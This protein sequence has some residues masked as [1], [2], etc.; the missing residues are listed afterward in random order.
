[1]YGHL[2]DIQFSLKNYIE[3]RKAWKTSLFLTIEKID[4]MDSELPDPEELKRKIR[5]VESS[6]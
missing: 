3:A 4:E 5:K 6:Q 1:L 2:G